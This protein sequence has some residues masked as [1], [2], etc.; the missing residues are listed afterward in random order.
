MRFWGWVVGLLG[1][2]LLS[3]RR[4]AGDPESPLKGMEAQLGVTGKPIQPGSPTP[5]DPALPSDLGAVSRIMV[6]HTAGSPMAHAADVD[7]Y[8]RGKASN[9]KAAIAYHYLVRADGSIERGRDLRWWGDHAGDTDN[10]RSVAVALTGNFENNAPPAAQERAAARL[11]AALASQ[12]DL[13]PDDV[14]GHGEGP[15]YTTQCPGARWNLD[16]FR[17]LVTAEG[18]TALWA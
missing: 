16:L 4:D 14:V 8:H 2:A 11:V 17:D 7:A 12:F 6:H 13:G 10:R 9:P 5:A 15:G 1:F 3:A 18:P